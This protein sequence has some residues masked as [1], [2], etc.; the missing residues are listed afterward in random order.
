[1]LIRQVYHL[2]E[3]P[4]FVSGRHVVWFDPQ[5]NSLP[6]VTHGDPGQMV[7]F[8]EKAE[9][10]KFFPDQFEPLRAFGNLPSFLCFARWLNDCA[11]DTLIMILSTFVEN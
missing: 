3:I 4:Q 10:L 11:T 5:A 2:T 9:L 7:D 6:G 1:M 8:M